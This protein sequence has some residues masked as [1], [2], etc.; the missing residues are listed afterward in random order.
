TKSIEAKEVSITNVHT[1]KQGAFCIVM[2][3]KIYRIKA[4][5]TI[6]KNLVGIFVHNIK[7]IIIKKIV[8]LMII[9]FIFAFRC[10]LLLF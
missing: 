9:F 10:I 8:E 6:P 4:I 3:N 2:N 7:N 5:K 1:F